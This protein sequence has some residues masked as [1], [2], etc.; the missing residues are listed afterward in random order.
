MQ[1][2][3]VVSNVIPA[4]EKRKKAQSISSISSKKL[5]LYYSFGGG[6]PSRVQM[7]LFSAL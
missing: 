6:L 1:R 2:S 5:V 7:P 3:S 4:P